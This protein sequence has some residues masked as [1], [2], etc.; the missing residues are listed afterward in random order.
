MTR[1]LAELL[2]PRLPADDENALL[3]ACLHQGERAR[4]GWTRWLAG[5]SADPAAICRDLAAART[6]LPLL[7]RSAAANDLALPPAAL[8]YVR[9]AALREE[10]RARRFRQI[11]A[12]ALARLA[13]AGAPV[14]VVRGAALAGTAYAE[15]SLRH[16]HDLDLLTEPDGLAAAASALA[17]DF[18]RVDAPAR[19]DGVRLRHASGLD[20]ALHT[21]PFAVAHYDVATAAFTAAGR[22]LAIDGTPARMPAPEATLVHVLGHATYSPSRRTLRWVADAWHLVARFTDLDWT[23]VTRRLVDYR[24]ALP[25]A[26]L[27]SHL[28]ALGVAIPPDVLAE[29]RA[30]ADAATTADQDVAI[31]GTL[32]G[33]GDVA[34]IWRAASWP[35]RRRLARWAVAPS[36]GYLRSAFRPP[37]RWRLALCYLDR[38]ARFV[39]R[40]LVRARID[41]HRGR[42]QPDVNVRL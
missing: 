12:E 3:E 28:A 29:V 26:G 27:L 24:L 10:R 2:A 4:R 34:A 6:L 11:A 32:S 37:S 33:G 23:A 35:A 41:E 15:W 9:A 7:A 39:R 30:R 21:R 22:D 5:R 1:P 25:V 38:P 17:A 20:I 31:A 19:G 8:A 36:P 14:F 40:S 18:A 42:P 13:R 16:C